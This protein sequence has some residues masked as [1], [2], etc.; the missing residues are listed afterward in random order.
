[1]TAIPNEA[2][3]GVRDDLRE[4]WAVGEQAWF[5]Y[6]CWESPES[7]D[8]EVWFHSHQ[9]AT[10]LAEGEHDGWEGST[11]AERAEA[12]QPKVY[13]VLFT[14]GLEWDVF[15]DELTTDPSGFVRPDPPGSAV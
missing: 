7:G 9:V 10:V 11:F 5:E 2:G 1:M 3:G 8:A 12:G 6:H 13:V 14:D 4:A 15:E